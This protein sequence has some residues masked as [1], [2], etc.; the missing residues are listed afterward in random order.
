MKASRKVD[1]VLNI[2]ITHKTAR[3][4]L[5]EAV[6]FQDKTQA[7]TEL[8]KI[9]GVEECLYLQTCNRIEI[10]LVAEEIGSILDKVKSFLANRA[11]D[12]VSEVRRAIETSID[13]E[14]VNHLLRVTSGLESL[15]IGEDQILNQ[16]WDAYIE[17]EKQKT[18]GP[19][20]KRLFNR[21]DAVGRK[22]R[23]ETG[24]NK[25][26]VSIGSAAVE[27]AIKVAG[28]LNNKRIL[29]MGAGEIGTLVAKAMARRC[30]SPIFIANRTYERAVKLAE[31]LS[32]RAVRWDKFD[33]VMADADVVFCATSAPHYLLTKKMI[34]RLVSERQNPNTMVIIDISNPRNVE[35]NVT[36]VQGVQLYNI[37]D[38]KLIA[39]TNRAQREAAIEQAQAIIDKELELFEEDMKSLS[40]R[41]IVTALLYE[42]EQIRQRELATA[43]AMMGQLDERQKRILNDLTS[44][45][46]KQ[47]YIPLIENLRLAAKN[48]DKQAIDA[49]AKLLEKSEKK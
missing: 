13:S 22:V 12:Q 36:E 35:K 5:M 6:A 9:E 41:L 11:G 32:G 31:E 29:I 42:A 27:L 2:R 43:M 44:I 10:Y 3:V 25:G 33:E 38:L 48:G 28:N 40:V 34:A 1:H 30:L 46:L 23:R 49:V 47:T 4:P 24:I 37:D 26:A 7:L 45:I 16:V 14:A 20:L 19:I 18:V 17:A 39:D 8:R 21:A 15:V